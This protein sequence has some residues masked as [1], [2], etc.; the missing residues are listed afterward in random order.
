M[1]IKKLPRASPPPN[2]RLDRKPVKDFQDIFVEF[3][4][5]VP[6]YSPSTFLLAEVTDAQFAVLD[7]IYKNQYC[8][9]GQLSRG[10]K[11]S[12]S[13]LTGIVE[14]LV[15]DGYVLR[16]RDET[17]RRVVRVNLTPKGKAVAEDL[18]KVYAETLSRI[19]YTLSPQDRKS[20]MRVIKKIILAFTQPGVTGH[21]SR[22]KSRRR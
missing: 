6:L 2:A 7:F 10:L 15:R 16:H 21:E 17:D 3:F 14:R 20:F 8:T 19:Y 1:T 13:T 11:A 9:M 18:K 22:V 12:L 4:R 5:V